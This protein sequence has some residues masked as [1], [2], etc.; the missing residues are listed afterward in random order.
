MLCIR[1]AKD[2]RGVCKEVPAFKPEALVD[3]LL[4]KAR[5]VIVAAEGNT[6]KSSL[7]YEIAEAI[8]T[9]N[10]LFGHLTTSVGNVK[11][12]Q[13]DESPIDAAT[14]FERMD[15]KPDNSRLNFKWSFN[16]SMIPDLEKDFE[17]EKTDLCIMD[18][19]VSI[20]GAGND[21][22]TPEV[23]LYLYQLNK[24][25]SRTGT[26]ILIPH[27]L[28]KDQNQ[29]KKKKK[30]DPEV[31]RAEV[32][33]DD[34]YG[35]VFIFNATS[36][37]WGLW[38]SGKEFGQKVFQLKNIKNRSMTAP[39]DHT[40]VFKG[41]EETNRYS[42][43]TRSNGD[44]DKAH[45]VEKAALLFLEN[46]RPNKYTVK[47]IYKKVSEVRGIMNGEAH[48]GQMLARLYTERAVSGIDRCKSEEKTGG[49]PPWAYYKR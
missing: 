31:F 25:A 17:R 2:L 22:N 8:T 18:S 4:P 37:A 9:G 33:K 24:I 26:T 21:L 7:C 23:G 42:I 13:G 6:G 5:M 14:K 12:V 35:N 20:F 27:H 1:V 28:K 10:K 39:S 34:L 45:T 15:F 49:R 40:F 36:D 48:L 29:S 19:L 38:V 44:L 11:I 16:P 32:T 3:R 30:D 41:S 47:E 43:S 46:N